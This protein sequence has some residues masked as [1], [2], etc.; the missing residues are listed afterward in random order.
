MSPLPSIDMNIVERLKSDHEFRREYFLAESSG[1]IARQL[2]TLRKRRGLSQHQV[3]D[4]LNTKQPAVSRVESADYRNWSFNT[5]RKLAEALD[6]RLR[7]YIEPFEDVLGDYAEPARTPR[8]ASV[9][10]LQK[11][12]GAGKSKPPARGSLLE[13]TETGLG[14]SSPKQ[15]GQK[16]SSI[17]ES[18]KAAAP[19]RQGIGSQSNITGATWNSSATTSLG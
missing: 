17:L 3:A 16:L 5:L 18:E 12:F 9:D 19:P 6:A 1:M 2:I 4:E 7:V 11:L 8:L 13:D 10:E 14:V 15:V